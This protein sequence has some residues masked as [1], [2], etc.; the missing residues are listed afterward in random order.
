MALKNYP[1]LQ[2]QPTTKTT[3]LWHLTPGYKTGASILPPRHIPFRL[4]TPMRSQRLFQ[5]LT[6][7]SSLILYFDKNS[8]IVTNSY[9]LI[10]LMVSFMSFSVSLRAF[11][12]NPNKILLDSLI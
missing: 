11:V 6:N 10:V 2:F 3:F 5:N 1:K 12:L 9:S 4:S 8:H 7:K